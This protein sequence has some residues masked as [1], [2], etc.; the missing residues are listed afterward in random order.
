MAPGRVAKGVR[1]AEQI[2]DGQVLLPELDGLEPRG[3][4]TLHRVLEA[5]GRQSRAVGD[6]V[7]REA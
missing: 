3:Q 2:A 7:E 5:R 6:E 4:A 1:E